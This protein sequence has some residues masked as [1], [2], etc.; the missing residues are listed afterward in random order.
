MSR[1][2]VTNDR[3]RVDQKGKTRKSASSAKPKRAAGESSSTP[4]KKKGATSKPKS[5]IGRLFGRGPAT[6]PV[7]KI[8]PTPEMTKLR[9]VWWVFMGVAVALALAMVP[10][11]KVNNTVSSILFGTYA[12]A[13]GGALYIEFGP[14]RRARMAAMKAAKG[15][16]AAKSAGKAAGGGKGDGG[17]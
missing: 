7:P 9:R 10:L 14:L 5:A 17:A 16:K 11:S 4:A 13:L 8:E 12:A 15:G 6:Q 3:Y 1:R 2:S